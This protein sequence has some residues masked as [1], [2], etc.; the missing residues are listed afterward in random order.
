MPRIGDVVMTPKGW[1]RIVRGSEWKKPPAR[2]GKWVFLFR[3]E[4]LHNRVIR[5][6]PTEISI[7]VDS[8]P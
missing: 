4:H 2:G 3:P 5:F 6:H 1:G 7:P 8:R